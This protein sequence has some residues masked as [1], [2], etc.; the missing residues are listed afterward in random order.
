MPN[1]VGFEDSSGD[2]L[3]GQALLGEQILDR[4]VWVARGER[5][6]LRA[7]PAGA[8]A[9]T[10][11]VDT[12]A[13]NACREFW[14]Q[15]IPGNIDAMNEIFQS[16]IDPLAQIRGLKPGYWASAVKVALE[17]LG[18]A[19]GTVR[20]PVTTEDRNHIVVITRKHAEG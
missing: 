18:R 4:F 6:A 10:G 14:K 13:P 2:V 19:G 15:G 7:L 8:R 3:I 20:P 17:A 12:L 16:R 1:V 11:A 5:H 9:Y